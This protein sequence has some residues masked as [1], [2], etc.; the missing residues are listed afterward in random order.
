MIEVFDSRARHLAR[1][2]DRESLAALAA[3][4]VEARKIHQR[5]AQIYQREATRTEREGAKPSV[6]STDSSPAL[7]SQS[8]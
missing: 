6:P 4:N 5:L 7:D 1:C 8:E 3:Y 2:S